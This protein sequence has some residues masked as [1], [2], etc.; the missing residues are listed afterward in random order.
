MTERAV[1]VEAERIPEG[2]PGGGNLATLWAWLAP[3][4]VPVL[5]VVT[6]LIIAAFI[7]I[8]TVQPQS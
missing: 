2:G 5:A 7:I 3:L 1:P 6:A 8:Y 4:M